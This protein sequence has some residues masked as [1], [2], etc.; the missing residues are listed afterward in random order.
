LVAYEPS[1]SFGRIRVASG[2][3]ST[4]R[5]DWSR[6]EGVRPARARADRDLPG[7]RATRRTEAEIESAHVVKPLLATNIDAGAPRGVVF[8]RSPI[9]VD[10]RALRPIARTLPAF[11]LTSRATQKN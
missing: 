7:S 11:L 1:S 6:A 9:V 2:S 8:L 4:W 3:T 5:R 10:C